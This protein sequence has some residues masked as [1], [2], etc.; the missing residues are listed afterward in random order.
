MLALLEGLVSF[1]VPHGTEIVEVASY[2][3]MVFVLLV[4]PQGLL[5]LKEG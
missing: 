1:L 3:L 4:R 5:G 2:G